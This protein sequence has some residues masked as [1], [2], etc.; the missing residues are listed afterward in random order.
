MS[1]HSRKNPANDSKIL[2]HLATVYRAVAS[3]IVNLSVK[4]VLNM[5]KDLLTPEVLKAEMSVLNLAGI[6]RKYGVSKQYIHQ[7]YRQ[8]AAEYPQ[9]F[10]E[11]EI[12]PEWLKEQLKTHTVLEICNMTGKSYHHI[13]NLMR[14]HNL[15]KHT[16]TAELDK[17]YI[18][19]QYVTL[20]QSDRSLA[21][22]YSCSVSLIRKFRHQHGILHA[23]RIPL[24][25]RLSEMVAKQHMMDGLSLLQ[26]SEQYD[27]TPYEIAKLLRSYSIEI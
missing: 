20:C 15:V 10:Y 24:S 22:H 7:L 17:T 26:L 19:E 4:G 25:E 12:E 3:Y 21:Q 1:G 5:I 23:D 2:K 6:A 16:T 18:R 14:Q 9:L 13:H 27:E 8:Y 11:P